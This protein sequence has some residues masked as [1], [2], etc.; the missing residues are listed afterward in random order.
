MNK[1]PNCGYT[2]PKEYHKHIY[3]CND[4]RYRIRVKREDYYE[5]TLEEAIKTRDR[6]LEIIKKKKE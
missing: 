1:C 4:V 2:P 5:K 6:I 3:Q